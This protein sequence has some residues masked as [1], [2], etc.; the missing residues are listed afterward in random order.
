MKSIKFI[1]NFGK[2]K[3]HGPKTY[4]TTLK[5]YTATVVETIVSL[6]P[7]YALL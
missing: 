5:I 7:T 6:A 3:Q 4:Y 2:Q 1:Y